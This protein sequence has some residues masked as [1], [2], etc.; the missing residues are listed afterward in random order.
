MNFF[1]GIILGILQGVTEFLPVSSSGHL[2]IFQEILKV[3]E[4][5]SVVFEVALHFATFLAIIMYY[6]RELRKI[7]LFCW[8][9]VRSS[10]KPTVI[11]SY[12]GHSE[13]L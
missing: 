11:I 5:N 13:L 7:V 6:R 9:S 8:S 10:T 12:F 4:H 3:K 1:D 2:V